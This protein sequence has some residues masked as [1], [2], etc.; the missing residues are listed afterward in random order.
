MTVRACFAC[1]GPATARKRAV[2]G[3]PTVIFHGS[4]VEGL[5]L[6]DAT[7]RNCTCEFD[8]MSGARTST[9]PV[10]EALVKDQRFLDGLVFMRH[11]AERLL[12]EEF[13]R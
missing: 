2:M 9:C 4:Q 5:A 12:A 6:A 8:D 10:H 13:T 11:L 3:L 1:D 7:N